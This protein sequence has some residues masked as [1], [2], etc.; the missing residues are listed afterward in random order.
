MQYLLGD[1]FRWNICTYISAWMSQPQIERRLRC[2]F[3]KLFV[4]IPCN[5]T[6]LAPPPF[7]S[8][9]PVYRCCNCCVYSIREGWSPNLSSAQGS[10]FT[11]ILCINTTGNHTFILSTNIANGRRL[12]VRNTLCKDKILLQLQESGMTISPPKALPLIQTHHCCYI[13]LYRCWHLLI[14]C[15]WLWLP[16]LNA[17]HQIPC[18]NI[19]E[20]KFSHADHLIL[21]GEPRTLR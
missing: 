14:S 1:D 13:I 11:S 12:L 3:G 18:T 20:R 6:G 9:E 16:V 2:S 21:S 4:D 5:L 10:E 19:L 8:T 15:W 17:Y 7:R